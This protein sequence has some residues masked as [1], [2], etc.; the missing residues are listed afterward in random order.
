MNK[1]R[2]IFISVTVLIAALTRFL[3]HPPNFT[4]IAA[5]A[6]FGGAFFSNKYLGFIVPLAAMLM[7]DIFIGF[8]N[9]IW[10]V[11][12]SFALIAGIGYLLKR[13][14][15]V[16]T[17]LG[18][19]LASSTLFFLITNFAVFLGSSFYPKSLAGLAECYTA[20]IP[21]FN[22]GILGDLVFTTVLFGGFYFAEIRIPAIAEKRI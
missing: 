2:I 21:F 16:I 3:P 11:Y 17:V 20:A 4:P 7:S 9:T 5:M 10:A 15:N 22:N 8:H 18:A 6:L 13:K 1:S 14:T 12:L 19:S